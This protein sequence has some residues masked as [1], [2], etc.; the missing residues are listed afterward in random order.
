M[1][2][3]Y[4]SWDPWVEMLTA[5]DSCLG[6][7]V[8]EA[9]VARDAAMSSGATSPGTSRR[10]RKAFDSAE[11]TLN[12]LRLGKIRPNTDVAWKRACDTLRK[13]IEALECTAPRSD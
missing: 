11:K 13:F 10:C 3:R 1:P 2:H 5:Q 4:V 8:R 12:T 6:R 7:I 9:I